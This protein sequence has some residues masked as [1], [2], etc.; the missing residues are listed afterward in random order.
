MPRA[1]GLK[2][3]TSVVLRAAGGG[4]GTGLLETSGKAR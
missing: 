4:D 1:N 2:S 3:G